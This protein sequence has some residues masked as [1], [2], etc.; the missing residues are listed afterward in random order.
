MADHSVF[1]SR[2]RRLLLDPLVA[3]VIYPIYYTFAAMP[4]GLA[5]AIG[6]RLGRLIGVLAPKLTRRALR[7]VERALPELPRER[8]RAIVRGMWDNLGRSLAE[9]PH[10]DQLWDG[11]IEMVGAEYLLA[12]AAKEKHPCLLVSGH[13]AN[14]ELFPST[15]AHHGLK[16]TVVYRKPN[17]PLIDY[18]MTGCRRVG[19]GYFVPKG[20][21]SARAM[22]K[23]LVNG[24][25]IGMLAD[26][27]FNDGI[28]VPF[29][30]IPAMTAPSLAQL[31][32]T[33]RC[34][35]VMGRPERLDGAHFRITVMPPELVPDTGN[36]EADVLAYMTRINALLESWI[37]ERP[38]Q[39]F[40]LHNRWPDEPEGYASLRT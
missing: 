37:R 31:A 13:I 3:V 18:L 22:I 7:N 19:G 36:R 25:A 23:T 14:W 34:P 8:H 10:I 26:Q 28:P 33:Y 32:L 12:L 27:K 29:F 9:H 11:R 2:M 5:S 39:W 35:V 20:Q 1:A 15:G 30:G 16:L 21:K 4:V 6:A 38:E 24:G 40:W 17:N